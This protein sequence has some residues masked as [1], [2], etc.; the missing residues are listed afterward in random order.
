VRKAKPKRRR[1][2]KTERGGRPVPLAPSEDKAVRTF[3]ETVPSAEFCDALGLSKDEK[4]ETLGRLMLDPRRRDTSFATKMIIAKVT[5]VDLYDFWSKHQLHVGLLKLANRVPKILDDV[6]QDAESKMV[7][8]SRCDGI[9]TVLDLGPN[10]EIAAKPRV[11]PLCEGTR[12]IRAVGDK[13]ARDLV[14][15]SVGL[16]GKRPP[17]VAIQQNF[18]LDAELGD[19]LLLSQ[20]VITGGTG[21]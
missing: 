15:E 1:L 9:G 20:K 7:A 19:V 18:G 4:F 6:A 21:Q 13:A 10:N 17:P 14:F 5:L 12:K 3:Y 16:T 8:C 11:C 2:Q